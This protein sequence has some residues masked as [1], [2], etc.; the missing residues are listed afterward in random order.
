VCTEFNQGEVCRDGVCGYYEERRAAD[1][2]EVDG[3]R[4]IRRGGLQV[5]HAGERAPHAQTGGEGEGG[6]GGGGGE[7]RA[8][9]GGDGAHSAG[10]AG[11]SRRFYGD[12]REN[13]YCGPVM[14][15]GV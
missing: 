4:E 12:V 15:S 13:V 14:Y 11:N 5:R 8:H 7:D 9:E 3:A 2:R 10:R 6:G 1:P